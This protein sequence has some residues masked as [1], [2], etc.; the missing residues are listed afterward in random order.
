MEAYLMGYIRL[1]T[2]RIT[3][4]VVSMIDDENILH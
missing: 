1:I 2:I 3:I 4:Q